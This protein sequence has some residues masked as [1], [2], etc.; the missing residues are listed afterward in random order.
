MHTSDTSG[1]N[2]ELIIDLEEDWTHC[3]DE[4]VAIEE[5]GQLHITTMEDISP[6]EVEKWYGAL[7]NSPE[8]AQREGVAGD[9]Q[10]LQAI[11][12]RLHSM[13]RTFSMRLW[14]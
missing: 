7:N 4:P 8:E 1:P 11:G 13:V 14:I 5:H 6:D 12:P 3:L 2:V 9:R 10:L